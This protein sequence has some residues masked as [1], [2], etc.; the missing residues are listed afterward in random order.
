LQVVHDDQAAGGDV[1]H[2]RVRVVEA[3][4]PGAL[5]LLVDENAGA[6][7]DAVWADAVNAVWGTALDAAGLRAQLATGFPAP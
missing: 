4:T 2:A 3:M 5:V 1:N 7:A 6:S